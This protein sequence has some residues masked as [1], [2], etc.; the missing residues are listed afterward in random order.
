MDRPS[1]SCRIGQQESHRLE[2]RY[3]CEHL[4]KVHALLLHVSLR[5]EP[6]LVHAD[7]A[8]GV[9][10]RLEDPLE[11]DR[12]DVGWSFLLLPT[13]RSSLLPSSHR[14]WLG[15]NTHA[16]APPRTMLVPPCPPSADPPWARARRDRMSAQHHRCS[17]ACGT[18]MAPRR[19]GS[20]PAASLHQPEATCA[21]PPARCDLCSIW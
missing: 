17:A 12:T 10:L 9:P 19:R 8:G 15:A 14:A 20:R 6:R 3:R 4:I 5:H 2:P 16:P 1:L 21:Q 7:V 11:A 13:S 18:T